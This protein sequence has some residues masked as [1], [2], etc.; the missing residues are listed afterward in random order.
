MKIKYFILIILLGVFYCK[1]EELIYRDFMQNGRLEAL[2]NDFSNEIYLIQLDLLNDSLVNRVLNIFPDLEL[3]AGPSSYHRLITYPDY[4]ALENHITSDYYKVLDDNYQMQ[5][6]RNYWTETL[7][8]NQYSSTSGETSPSC[9]CIDGPECIVVGYNDSWYNPFD[10]YGEAS[11][12]FIP[13]P[14]DQIV[15]ARVYIAG[16]QCDD[17]PLWSETNLSVKNNDCNWSDFQVTLSAENTINGPYIISDTLLDQIWCN[18]SLEPV[19]GSEDNYNVDWVQI[20]LY[21]SCDTPINN[22]NI[23]ASD[24][25]FCEYVEINWDTNDSIVGFNLYKDGDFISN[26]NNNDN[27]FVDYQA[28][29]GVEHQYCLT[30]VNDCGE[31]E[32]VC[33]Y[34][35]RQTGPLSPSYVN[36]SNNFGN[37]IS[38]SWLESEETNYYNLYRDGFLL[39]V[40]PNNIFEYIDVFVNHDLIYEYCLESVNDCGPS[41]WRCDSGSLSVGTIGDVNLDQVI[42]ILD[43]IN[44]LNFVLEQS[45][46]SEDEFWLSDINSDGFLN[47]LD[48]VLIVN[49]ILA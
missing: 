31:S 23:S 49:I 42:D 40:M 48:I 14:N 43:V 12:S 45:M 10:Y 37:Q 7:E 34:G 15:E 2:I 30:E 26:F 13:P 41:D 9:M 19:I 44:I 46:P 28:D 6:T 8:G 21:Y 33:N 27:Q 16:S 36:A 25:Q 1:Q 5:S 29:I 4:L 3:Y 47:V 32:S 17:L 39:S 22:L 18:G 20:E 35:S 24:N 38:I 11:W